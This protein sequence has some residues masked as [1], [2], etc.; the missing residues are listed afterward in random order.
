MVVRMGCLPWLLLM[1]EGEVVG[2]EVLYLDQ[3]T[4]DG[5]VGLEDAGLARGD[6][7]G[8][9]VVQRGQQP[10]GVDLGAE[11]VE[12]GEQPGPGQVVVAAGGLPGLRQYRLLPVAVGDE[13]ALGGLRVV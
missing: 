4:L 9:A 11:P 1:L 8:P 3:A 5:G 7:A 13:R 6:P 10:L 2:V 12:R